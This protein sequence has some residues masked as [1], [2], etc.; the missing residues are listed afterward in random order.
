MYT[1]L[2]DFEESIVDLNREVDLSFPNV[3]ASVRVY[4]YEYKE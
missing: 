3:G 4:V 2:P 1:Y